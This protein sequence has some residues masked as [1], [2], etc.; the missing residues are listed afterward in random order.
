MM[1]RKFVSQKRKEHEIEEFIAKTLPRVGQSRIKLQRT[2]L[3]EKII[4]YASRPG[5]VVGTKGQNIIK[6]TSTLKKKFGLE[7]PQI[8]VGEVENISLDAKIMAEKIANLLERFGTARF[9]GTGHKILE[10][11]MGAGALGIEILIS[12]KIPGARAK[13][14]RFYQGYLKKCGD[15]SDVGVDTAYATANLKS[16]AVGIKVS[17]MPSTIKLPDKVNLLSEKV[18]EIE[19]VAEEKVVE[20]KEEKLGDEEKKAED[21]KEKEEKSPKV[22]EKKE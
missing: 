2:P 11:V 16:G 3:G 20:K 10:E 19:E 17:I 5:L 4:I 21:K 9:K 7:N 6:L 14:W 13:R 18:E 8:E 15:I 1:E 22:K 12:G